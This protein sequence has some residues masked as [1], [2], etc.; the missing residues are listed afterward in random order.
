MTDYD[1]LIVGGGLVGASLALACSGSGW[2]IGVLEAKPFG[3]SDQPS[4]DDRSVALSYSS[5]RILAGL[6]LW[7]ALQ[8]EAAPIRHIQVSSAGR[9]GTTRIDQQS[10]PVPALG[11]VVTNR[12]LGRA[13]HAGLAAAANVD[14]RTPVQVDAIEPT[15]DHVDV[16]AQQNG[17]PRTLRS[18]LLVGADGTDSGVRAA[19]N[20]DTRER[21]YGQAAVSAN[22]TPADGHHDWAYER[23]TEPGPLALLPLPAGHCSLVWCNA[24]ARAAALAEMT[25]AA[26]LHALQQC[27]G[28]R[29]GRFTEVGR[30]TVYPLRLVRAARDITT[31]SVLIGNAAHTLHPVAGQGFNLALRDVAWLAE[32]LQ[33]AAA[34]G[35]EPGTETLLRRYARG[36]ARDIN[37]TLGFTDGLIRLFG[38]RWPGTGLAQSLGLLGLD[39]MP[40][41]K[42]QL[43]RQS[44]GLRAPVTRLARGLRLAPQTA[45]QAPAGEE[46]P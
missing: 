17:L 38:L 34:A 7:D 42:Q 10:Q 3:S 27:F 22:V 6:G 29:M 46:Q 28:W 12:S 37:E 44:M 23:F 26:F 21:D 11:Y 20:I 43:T 45:R 8:A 5:S 16:T 9:F 41:F 30:R 33:E 18:R 31:R 4:Y 14:L 35:S 40:A 2:R 19:L 39:A 24:P 1:I 36:R 25:D 13:L 32:L 15:R